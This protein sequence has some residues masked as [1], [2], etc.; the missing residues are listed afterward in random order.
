MRRDRHTRTQ[1]QMQQHTSRDITK[2]TPGHTPAGLSIG[3]TQAR[4][5]DKYWGGR[6][7]SGFHHPVTSRRDTDRWTEGQSHRIKAWDLL[8]GPGMPVTACFDGT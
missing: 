6:G 4:A 8:L 5:R 2:H 1:E 3:T 7:V